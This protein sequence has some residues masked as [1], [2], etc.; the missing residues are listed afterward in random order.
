MI[1]EIRLAH[2]W[3]PGLSARCCRGLRMLPLQATCTAGKIFVERNSLQPYVI[4]FMQGKVSRPLVSFPHTAQKNVPSPALIVQRGY[5]RPAM[6]ASVN[7]IDISHTRISS[8]STASLLTDACR[9]QQQCC[10]LCSS[11]PL[12]HVPARYFPAVT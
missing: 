12:R 3:E 4:S 5:W 1:L 2:E 10:A 11:K 8:K 7:C 6:F 9:L